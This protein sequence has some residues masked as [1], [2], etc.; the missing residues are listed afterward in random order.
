SFMEYVCYH[1]ACYALAVF[2]KY[3]SELTVAED[4]V[5]SALTITEFM[6]LTFFAVLLGVV[7]MTVGKSS[8]FHRNMMRI[9]SFLIVLLY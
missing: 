2:S 3:D 9:S 1:K 7:A 5:I 6:F 4:L 8:L